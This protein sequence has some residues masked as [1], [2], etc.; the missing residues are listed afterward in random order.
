VRW[1]AALALLGPAAAW[2]GPTGHEVAAAR[3]ATAALRGLAALERGGVQLGEAGRSLAYARSV[4]AY[5]RSES[6]RKLS[7]YEVRR[8]ARRQSARRRGRALYKLSRGGVLRVL[9]DEDRADTSARITKARTVRAL[10]RHDLAELAVYRAAERRAGA[11]LAASVRTSQALSALATF[12]DLQADLVEGGREGLARAAAEAETAVRRA[13]ARGARLPPGLR[14]SLARER[15]SLRRARR[16]LLRPRGLVRPVRGRV[17]GRFGPYR[18][19]VLR[20]E[21]ERAGIELAARPG[22]VVRAVAAGKVVF[23]GE[24]PGFGLVAVI[25]HGDGFLS[26]TG[27]LMGLVVAPEAQ[28]AA[29][30]PLGR[31]APK[32]EDDGLGTTVYLELRHGTRPIDPAPLLARRRRRAAG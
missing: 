17:V 9:F 11:A 28:V 1:V 31:A 22:E 2:A 4:L 27:R 7:A 26:V 16:S 6:V 20:V 8:L 24:I 21:A 29:G 14:R 13:A 10:V 5:E 23:T 32:T 12:A 18:D 19:K 3:R 30:G 15:R 25:D